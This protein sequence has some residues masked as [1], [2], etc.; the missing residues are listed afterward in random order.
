VRLFTKGVVCGR[1]TGKGRA[2]GVGSGRES[3]MGSG[4]VDGEGEGWLSMLWALSFLMWA[5]PLGVFLAAAPV[6]VI[7][8]VVSRL[9]PRDTP[10]RFMGLPLEMASL[11][12]SSSSCSPPSLLSSREAASLMPLHE[13]WPRRDGVLGR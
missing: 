12:V 5:V 9:P 8:G 3:G 2:S 11:V 10:S 13:D 1:G 6:L 7:V 4:R